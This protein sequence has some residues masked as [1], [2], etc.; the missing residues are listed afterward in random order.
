MFIF[1]NT[2]TMLFATMGP[3][4]ALIVF[5]EKTKGVDSSVR[6]PIVYKAVGVAIGVGLLFIIFGQFLMQLFKF[7]IG[8]LMVAGGVILLI[9]SI[10][11]VLMENGHKEEES[12]GGDIS[13]IAIY[14]LAIPIMA[15]PMGIVVLTMASAEKRVTEENVI[16]LLIAFLAV[17]AINLVALLLEERVVKYISADILYV[18]E[19]ILGILLAA[20]AVQTIFNGIVTLIP[21]VY[22]ILNNMPK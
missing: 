8:A 14:P 13:D 21:Q 16:G 15:S 9:F 18:A 22:E 12:E 20:L 5:A 6:R 11:M 4:K 3:I 1:I 2:F 10:R 19:R 7:S 17:M